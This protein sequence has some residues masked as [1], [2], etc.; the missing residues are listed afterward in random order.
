MSQNVNIIRSNPRT[1]FTVLPN[2][3][4]NDARLSAAAL[5]LL[6]YVLSRPGNWRVV[7]DQLAHR[8][9]ISYRTTLKILN[10][11]R[12]AGYVVRELVFDAAHRIVGTRYIVH[13]EPQ[14]GVNQATDDDLGASAPER[15]LDLPISPHRFVQHSNR[16]TEKQHTV[17]R[18]DRHKHQ[19]HTPSA[20][21]EGDEDGDPVLQAIAD[22]IACAGDTEH[23]RCVVQILKSLTAVR[24]KQLCAQWKRR[25][26]VRSNTWLEIR[27]AANELRQVGSQRA[28]DSRENIDA[29]EAADLPASARARS[30]SCPRA[31]RSQAMARPAGP[32]VLQQGRLAQSS[33]RTSGVAA[34][35]STAVR[36]MPRRDSAAAHAGN[37][38]PPQEGSQ[39]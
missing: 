9:G 4:A 28:S 3:V 29:D 18:K 6:Y 1:Q 24:R 10:E 31:A 15:K 5:G 38:G 30:Q 12:T 22:D 33:Q 35:A 20:N 11:L 17:I 26:R 39:G 36:D 14:L 13:D 32:P 16:L 37:H 21:A 34:A 2:T 27:Q 19:P 25:G 8:F 23:A 7:P